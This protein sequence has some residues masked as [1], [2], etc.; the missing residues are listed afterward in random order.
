ML[1]TV[2]LAQHFGVGQASRRRKR[3]RK[4][5]RERARQSIMEAEPGALLEQRHDSRAKRRFETRVFFVLHQETSL[6]EHVAENDSKLWVGAQALREP[7]RAVEQGAKQLVGPFDS[8]RN[9]EAA[10]PTQQQKPGDRVGLERADLGKSAQKRVRDAV[11]RTRPNE[12]H[13]LGA[14]LAAREPRV[15]RVPKGSPEARPE[16]SAC[17]VA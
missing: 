10:Q 6:A 11:R 4:L 16:Q 2:H 3:L 1:G 8:C 13:A 17:V 9:A 15:Q 7:A 12:Q 5:R 14:E